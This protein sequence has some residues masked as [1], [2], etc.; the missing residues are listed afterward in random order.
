MALS[1]FGLTKTDAAE[2]ALGYAMGAGVQ[3]L[4]GII[5]IVASRK[6]S[7]WMFTKDDE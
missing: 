2:M 1:S 6:I 5:L 7:G 3:V 4:F